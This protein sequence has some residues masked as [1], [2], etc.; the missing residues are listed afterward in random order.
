MNNSFEISTVDD[1]IRI[2]KMIESLQDVMSIQQE[3]LDKLEAEI[4]RVKNRTVWPNTSVRNRI[5]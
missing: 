3:R 1:T 2:L 4:I 5:D